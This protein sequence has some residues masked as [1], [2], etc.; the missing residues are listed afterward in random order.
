MS[1]S[2]VP[3]PKN[4]AIRKWRVAGLITLISFVLFA[5]S[6]ALQSSSPWW[7]TS[8]SNVAGSM[9]LLIPA[10]LALNM[11]RSQVA[12][13]KSV[14]D[15]AQA[16]ADTAFETAERTA[17]SLDDIRNDIIAKQTAELEQEIAMY[18]QVTVDASR[19][20]LIAALR[21]ATEQDLVTD[22]GVRVPVWWTGLH[23][24]FVVDAP[25]G[26]LVVRLEQDDQEVVS[27]HHWRKDET[28]DSFYGR[29][30]TAVRDAGQDLGTGLNVPTDS[31]AELVEMLVDV[32]HLRSQEP[33]GHRNTLRKIIERREGWYFTERFV[34]PAKQLHYTIDVGRLDDQDWETHLG[35]KP[36]DNNPVDAIRFA[37]RLYGIKPR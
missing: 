15:A 24:R 2:D 18:K 37:R 16:R 21:H 19:D 7:S 13:T 10:E 35:R 6:F 36:W 1:V 28:A 14:A 5:I 9:L 22:S 25:K 26:E 3:P 27:E 34:I 4:H 11:F 8:L 30:V 31:V 33:M 20:T 17:Q 32:T 29:L 23:Y 12:A